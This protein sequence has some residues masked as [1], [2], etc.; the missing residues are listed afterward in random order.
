MGICKKQ[1]RMYRLPAIIHKK[2]NHKYVKGRKAKDETI[3]AFRRQRVSARSW[4]KNF[5]NKTQK[6]LTM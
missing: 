6:A 4:D 2:I 3:K 1:M 5:L